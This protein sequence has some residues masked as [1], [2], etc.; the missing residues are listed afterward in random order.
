MLWILLQHIRKIH[1]FKNI[2]PLKTD[3]V[4]SQEGPLSQADMFLSQG[5]P[6]E[7]V[8]TFPVSLVRPQSYLLLHTVYPADR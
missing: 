3:K 4:Q 2:K 7:Q 5:S 6:L 8:T 1:S